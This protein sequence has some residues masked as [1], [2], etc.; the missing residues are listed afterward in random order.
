MNF[1]ASSD[2]HLCLEQAKFLVIDNQDSVCVASVIEELLAK[3]S[4]LEDHSV[5][6]SILN[7]SAEFIKETSLLHPTVS[8]VL[9]EQL[10]SMKVSGPFLDVLPTVFSTVP[11]DQLESLAVN[12]FELFKNEA[13]IVRVLS[14]LV[15]LPLSA[16]LADTINRMLVDT[17]HTLPDNHADITALFAI[18]LRINGIKI[19]QSIVSVWREKVMQ[20]SCLSAHN[21]LQ[22]LNLLF[23]YFSAQLHRASLSSLTA[24]FEKLWSSLT[25][26][27]RF[28]VE[29]LDQ[30]SN[31]KDCS[32]VRAPL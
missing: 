8:L 27:E 15:E 28:G 10:P 24:V 31:T 16:R 14:I 7:E 19:V 3:L 22:R 4:E 26:F 20:I 6:I 11:S 1:L 9:F 25:V 30:M 17:L 21:L 29:W 12:L 32:K 13:C 23:L 18:S 2:V 5:N